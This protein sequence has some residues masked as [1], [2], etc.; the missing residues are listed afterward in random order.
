M[1]IK[2]KNLRF[3]SRVFNIHPNEWKNITNAWLI[4]FLYK[5]GFVIGWS[6]L[7]V[8]FVSNYGISALP[9]LF[10]LNA[11]FSILGTFFYSFLV[12]KFSNSHLMLGCIF[13]AGI[14]LFVST[15]L[16][17]TNPV[18][19]FAILIVDIAIFLNQFK[20]GLN[21]YTEELFDPLQSER[22]FPFIEAAET[23]SG[24]LAGI[25]VMSLSS[26]IDAHNFIYLWIASLFLIIP[27]I[28]FCE[29]EDETV[30]L[31]KS[32]TKR[33]FVMG[34]MT[35][36]K[37]ES[38][39]KEYNFVKGLALIVLF[40]WL[41]FNLLEFQYTTAVY[42]NV[43]DVIIDAG[44]GFEHA[45]IH[46]LGTLF[47]IFSS[48][49]LLIQLI[50]GSRIINSLGVVG[51]MLLHCLVSLFSFMGLTVSFNFLT[52]VFVKNNYTMTNI[53]HTNAYHSSYYA[54]KED[55]RPYVREFLE[56]IVR[57][58]GALI[59]T[60][61]LLAVQFVFQGSTLILYINFL[62]V[63]SILIALMI[64]LNQ[65]RLYTSTAS[66]DLLYSKNKKDKINAI[67]ILSQKG[68]KHALRYYK[69]ILLDK[70]E[71]V[72]IRVR[73]L[74]A[75]KE[76]GDINSIDYILKCLESDK[77]A[78]KLHA[79]DC[80]SSFEVL[81]KLDS[82]SIYLKYKLINS[83]KQLYKNEKSDD[84]IYKIIEV[85]S[86][87]S[88][89]ATVE[90]LLSILNK[91]HGESKVEAINAIGNYGDI[92]LIPYVRP[93][94]KARSLKERAAA[95]IVLSKFDE[96]EK[97]TKN[98]LKE[99]F[100]LKG[101]NS[102]SAALFIV[103]EIKLKNKKYFCLKYLDSNKL[104]LRI[105]SSIALAKMADERSIPTIVDLL[106]HENIVV[107]KKV[108]KLI[109]KVDVRIAKKIASI[110]KVSVE[111]KINEI[112][113]RESNESL[114]SFS[115]ENLLKLKWFYR[116][117]EEYEEVELINNIIKSNKN[118]V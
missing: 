80:L 66:Y 29:S 89:I 9:Y 116:L 22:T 64:T 93:F 73:I 100:A 33:K 109:L 91:S 70:E 26:S 8:L 75:L 78:I 57:P 43:S 38:H 61:A 63:V 74:K 23:V 3:L 31:L 15:M 85:M 48:S 44:S 107:A 14:L 59:G 1:K 77:K 84:I 98:Y 47:L 17:E 46:D 54:I 45:F 34:L 65:Q 20:I 88:S 51:T 94:L 87:T 68:H 97:E 53:L 50:I 42:H 105:N 41:I 16:F 90:F 79:L 24:I 60:L 86:Q 82:D 101:Q 108:Y 6:V 30:P 12:D 112:L 35:K 103:G 18:L 111:E 72:S 102:L 106:F 69:K 11:V 36:W 96:F 52:A 28:L 32:K 49:A 58:L 19:F 2:T 81:K 7:V 5:F 37:K 56:G 62:L 115:E 117:V 39:S 27:L 40:Q 21:S 114:N 95:I 92:N 104:N 99:F 13:L 25:T 76:L 4:R 71:A 67:D 55:T 110:V 10:V 118:T 113:S 83:L